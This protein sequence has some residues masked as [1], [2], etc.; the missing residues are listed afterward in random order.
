MTA[1]GKL[2]TRKNTRRGKTGKKKTNRTAKIAN[3]MDWMFM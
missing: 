3:M 1:V 2:T